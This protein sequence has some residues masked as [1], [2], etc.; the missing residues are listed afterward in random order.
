MPTP[1][2]T[3][4]SPGF[5]ESLIADAEAEEDAIERLIAAHAS[6]D[7]VT[8]CSVLDALVRMRGLPITAYALTPRSPQRPAGSA[9]PT[10]H[11]NPVP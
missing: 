5:L 11:L 1:F 3:K 4:L 9:A 2:Q 10:E 8:T 6:G 7:S